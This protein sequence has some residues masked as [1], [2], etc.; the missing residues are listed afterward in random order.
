[1]SVL[2]V[3]LLVMVIVG[4]ALVLLAAGEPGQLDE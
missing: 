4:V 2:I 1:M 3:A